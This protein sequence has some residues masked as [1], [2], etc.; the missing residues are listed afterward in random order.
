MD[1]NFLPLVLPSQGIGC[2]ASIILH[3]ANV[4]VDAKC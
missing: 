4:D 1:F 2:I 3:F